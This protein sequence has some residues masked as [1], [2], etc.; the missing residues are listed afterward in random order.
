MCKTADKVV[1]SHKI[2]R[3]RLSKRRK[4]LRDRQTK[5]Y[6]HKLNQERWNKMV[7]K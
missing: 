2:K 1:K 3:K 5:M 4:E 6:L 7:M